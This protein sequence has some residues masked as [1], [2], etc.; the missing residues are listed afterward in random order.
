M[1]GAENSHY[2]GLDEPYLCGNGPF[3]TTGQMALVKGSEKIE[4]DLTDFLTVYSD[5]LI[6]INTATKE[7]LQSLD[8]EMDRYLA[9]AIVQ[10]RDERDFVQVNDIKN[11]SGMDEELFKRIRPL[12][13]V[14]SSCFSLT[15]K[16]TCRGAV[17]EIK[18]I[19]LRDEDETRLI[20]WRIM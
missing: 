6:N 9:E 5:G 4:R 13:T 12:I 19:T 8:N 17:K 20:Y 14:K 18:A 7:V 1:N 15:M 16:G 11:V 3:L 2:Q 10:Y